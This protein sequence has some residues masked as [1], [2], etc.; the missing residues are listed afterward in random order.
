MAALQRVEFGPQVRQGAFFRLPRRITSGTLDLD[1]IGDLGWSPFVQLLAEGA[2][3]HSDMDAVD[4]L[5]FG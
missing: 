4:L 2:V 5:V 1:V 3:H